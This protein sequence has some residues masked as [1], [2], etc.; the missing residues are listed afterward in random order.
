M[1]LTRTE[2]EHIGELARLGLTDEEKD[3][4]ATQL[5]DI[6]EHFEVLKQLDTDEVLPTATVMPLQNVMREDVM[7][8]SLAPDDALANA[9]S[10]VDSFFRVRAILE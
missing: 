10:T 5:S 7:R 6:L 4:F 2:V 8:P 1:G 9:P 3:L